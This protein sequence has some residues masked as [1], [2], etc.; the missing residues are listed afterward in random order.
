MAPQPQVFTNVAK[1]GT[2]VGAPAGALTS[3]V[4]ASPF[5]AGTWVL[6]AAWDGLGVAVTGSTGSGETYTSGAPSASP[7]ERW[8]ASG[9]G[10]RIDL[11]LL[12]NGNWQALL[13]PGF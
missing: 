8:V 6:Q 9:N 4:A 13:F 1:G 7:G 5:G 2:F 12:S 11:V 3:A 10:A